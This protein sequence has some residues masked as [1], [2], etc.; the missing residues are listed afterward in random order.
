MEVIA[1]IFRVGNVCLVL[2]IVSIHTPCEASHSCCSHKYLPL[3]IAAH[4]V[5]L[6][7]LTT[8]YESVIGMSTQSVGDSPCK[9]YESII[10]VSVLRSLVHRQL[11]TIIGRVDIFKDTEYTG[12][13][14]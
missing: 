3:R 7:S 4:H 12:I 9:S 5:P 1:G 14:A 11:D 8:D 13:C 6:G 10:Q 2:I